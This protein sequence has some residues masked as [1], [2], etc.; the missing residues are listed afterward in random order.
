MEALLVSLITMAVGTLGWVAYAHPREYKHFIKVP[1]MSVGTVTIFTFTGYFVAL[2]NA[3]SA[4][5]A[6]KLSPT[7]RDTVVSA[8]DA[9][10]F[11]WS[12]AIGLYVLII[13]VWL[14]SYLETIG[15]TRQPS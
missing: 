10:M 7:Q 11:P 15:L 1:I 4:V 5:Y 13:Y 12:V 2:V 9:Y 6:S 14:L 8:I 3:K